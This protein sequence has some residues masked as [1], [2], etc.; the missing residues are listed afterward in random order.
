[1]KFMFYLFFLTFTV[2]GVVLA[3]EL[4]E[5]IG[6]FQHEG[7]ASDFGSIGDVNNDGQDDFMVAVQR[8][9]RFEIFFGS[10]DMGGEVDHLINVSRENE[11]VVHLLHIGRISPDHTSTFLTMSALRNP[12]ETEI[13]IDF[14][15]GLGEDQDSLWDTWS[16][17][18]LSGANGRYWSRGAHQRPFD[19]NGDGFNDLALNREISD[20]LMAMDVYFGGADFDS[21]PDWTKYFVIGAGGS[22]GFFT[23]SSGYD[24]NGDG[25]HDMLI[26]GYGTDGEV[27]QRMMYE[28]YLG[29]EEPDTIPVVHIWDGD[30][31]GLEY[32]VE[33]EEGFSLLPDLND[34]G[35]AEFGLY[36]KEWRLHIGMYQDGIYLFFGAEEVDAE[37]DMIL[38]GGRSPYIHEGFL[39]SGDFNGDGQGDL[40]AGYWA[41]SPNRNGEVHFHFGNAHFDSVA[42]VVVS[43]RD[44]DG[45]YRQLGYGIGG[46]GDYNGDGADDVAAR[47]LSEVKLVILAGN[48]DWEVSVP[49]EAPTQV[50]DFGLCSYPNPFNS[51]ITLE[52]SILRR[53]KYKI[54]ILDISGRRVAVLHD[55]ELDSGDH[56]LTWQSPS[57]GVFFAVLR[58]GESV[59][60]SKM[61]C[62]K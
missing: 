13:A 52:F 19:F 15:S 38:E 51:S 11:A 18:Y 32:P 25:Y 41:Q 46:V 28:L 62:L 1:M 36:Y 34:D 35:Y 60:I 23:S 40:V 5:I 47:T 48:P 20:S 42:D 54:E 58:T 14:H 39:T 45:Q 21:I 55:S 29:G 2:V 26:R 43:Q 31:M 22:T 16:S 49:S 59:S 30:F 24:V 3:Y 8:E 56:T 44:Y 4:P 7:V 27:R 37:P 6:E 12:E 9:D 17:I 57:A 53:G 33:M 50:A 61:V 10:N